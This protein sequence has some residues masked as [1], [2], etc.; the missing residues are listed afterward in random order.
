[1]RFQNLI[2]MQVCLFVF[3]ICGLTL[4][5]V[6]GICSWTRHSAEYSSFSALQPSNTRSQKGWYLSA[7][8]QA[9][10]YSA[11]ASASPSIMNI[12][13]FNGPLYARVAHYEGSA[14][15]EANFGGYTA[16]VP[17]Y[18]SG[19]GS[20]C[21]QSHHN[22]GGSSSG[23]VTYKDIKVSS[24]ADSNT[25]PG[26]SN[27]LQA[28]VKMIKVIKRRAKGSRISEETGKKVWASGNFSIG[29]VGANIGDEWEHKDGKVYTTDSYTEVHT[30]E[31]DPFTLGQSASV[32]DLGFIYATS[33]I[34][35]SADVS[36]FTFDANSYS[37]ASATYTQP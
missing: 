21:V 7:S 5:S 19:S 37:S 2:R 3:V 9:N 27:L 8:V 34:N 30:T 12:T 16:R 20:S 29:E 15:V 36:D 22:N 4:L 18:S 32:F 6:P 35:T 10:I 1:M 14:T 13:L 23:S 31:P 17:Q 11:S 28:S 24:K 26:E 33:K 25:D